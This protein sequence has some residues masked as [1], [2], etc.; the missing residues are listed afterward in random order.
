MRE[1]CLSCG[2]ETA[3]GSALYSDRRVVT[4]ESRDQAF[5]CGLCIQRERERMGRHLT[6]EDV[7][8]FAYNAQAAMWTPG[9]T[10]GM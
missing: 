6:D 8:R 10:P 7:R 2:E 1:P 9:G 4:L 5:L 3:P